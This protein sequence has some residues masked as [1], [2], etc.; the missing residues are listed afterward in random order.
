MKK[1]H[2]ILL[3]LVML[4]VGVGVGRLSA[5]SPDAPGGPGDSAASM[6]TLEQIYQRIANGGAY[7][8]TTTFTEPSTPPGTGTMHNLN[9]IY[10]LIGM[11][12]HVPRTT[13][14]LC[15][16][17]T[18]GDDG[19][20]RAGALWPVPR[21]T[22]RGDGSVTDNLTGLIWL[23]EADCFGTRTWAQA[24]GDANAL[25]SGQCSL[26]DGS[27]AGHWRLPN[28]RELLSL[29]DYNRSAP[30]FPPVHPFSNLQASV[31]Y[32]SSTVVVNNTANAW[33]ID[34]DIGTVNRNQLK[35][36]LYY[37]WPVS[38]GQVGP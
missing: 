6:Y 16:C 27:T 2:W 38:G 8:T 13:Q 10:S 3:A 9:D 11:T 29:I 34:F 21:F 20:I 19:F 5:G 24:I 31:R 30:A 35:T 26:T 32:W 7:A 4:M 1:L 14:G 12:A 18:P 22:D 37:V 36:T 15:P 33:N 28:I 17:E 25:V 23:K